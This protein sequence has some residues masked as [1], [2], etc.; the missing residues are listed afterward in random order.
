MMKIISIRTHLKKDITEKSAEKEALR[1]QRKRLVVP[2]RSLRQS[3][4][5]LC[6]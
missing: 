5:F 3:L 6:G 2:L 1:V 4:F